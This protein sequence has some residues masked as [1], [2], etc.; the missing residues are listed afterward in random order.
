MLRK[1]RIY[2]AYTRISFALQFQY[3]VAMFI[4]MIGA[5][6]QP[7]VY[8]VV[9]ATVARTQGGSVGG[10]TVADFSAY[11][12]TLMFVEHL[13]FTWIMWEWDWRIRRGDLSRLLLLPLHPVHADIADNIAFKLLGLIVL[14]PGALALAWTF[15]PAFALRADALLLF[16]PAFV[17]AFAIRFMLGYVLGMLAFW[18]ERVYAINSIYFVLQLFFSGRL[19]PLELLPSS[20]QTVANVL[21]FKWYTAFPVDLLLGRLSPPAVL[22]GLLVQFL[23]LGLMLALF[24]LVW[25]QGVR[26]YAAYG[27]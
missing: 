2:W 25:R 17:M 14:V 3:R 11:Y 5:V 1:L 13:T 4:W 12:L 8:L 19:T 27:A 16:V 9:W 6:I 24:Q 21:P 20:L 18:F 15:R 23:W 7:A 22:Q 10:L 26:R